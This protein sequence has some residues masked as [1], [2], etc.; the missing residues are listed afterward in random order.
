MAGHSSQSF[1]TLGVTDVHYVYVW[2]VLRQFN[3][4]FDVFTYYSALGVITK[5]IFEHGCFTQKFVHIS[6]PFDS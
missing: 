5:R 4:I 3:V 6:L 2:D 1:A